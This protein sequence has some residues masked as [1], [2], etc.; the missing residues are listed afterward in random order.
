M[1]GLRTI[2]E[3]MEEDNLD[4]EDAEIIYNDERESWLDYWVEPYDP[5][6][7]VEL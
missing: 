3:I 4:Y 1:H 6:N 2:D 5:K 7:W